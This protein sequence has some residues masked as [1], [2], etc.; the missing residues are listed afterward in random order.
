[1]A[2]VSYEWLYFGA[3]LLEGDMGQHMKHEDAHGF[4]ARL[5]EAMDRVTTLPPRGEGRG[6]WLARQFDVTEATANGWL[7]GRFRPL[8]AR[9][10]ALADMLG[11]S[12]DWLYFGTGSPGET[13]EQPMRKDAGAPSARV[14]HETLASA[15][16]LVAQAIGRDRHLR[17]QEHAALVLMVMDLQNE[18]LPEARVIDIARRQA[19]MLA[20]APDGSST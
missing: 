6:I 16:R 5:N 8:P 10:R 4:S 11:V 20:T 12:H 2:G 9:A 17:P 18:G 7:T 3:G 13:H 19:A 1:M 15:L 14:L